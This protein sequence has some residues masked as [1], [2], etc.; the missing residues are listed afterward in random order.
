MCSWCIQ[1]GTSLE[2]ISVFGVVD[3]FCVG[4]PEA[5]QRAKRLSVVGK[6]WLSADLLPTCVLGPRT[7]ILL[8]FAQV[9]ILRVVWLLVKSIWHFENRGTPGIDSLILLLQLFLRTMCKACSGW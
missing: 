7:W 9:G 5:A 1:L 8:S 3:S 2:E 4:P 6:G